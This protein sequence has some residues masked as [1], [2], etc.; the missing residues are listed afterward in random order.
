MVKVLK[1][2]VTSFKTSHAGTATLSAPTLQQATTNPC[3]DS[4]TLMGKSGSVSFGVTALFSWVLGHKVLFVPSKS[5]FP[6][7]VKVL[8]WGYW[9]SKRAYTKPRSAAPRASAPVAVHC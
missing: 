9:C 8:L 3:G 4:W 5:L 6:S 7:P 2:M 1:I